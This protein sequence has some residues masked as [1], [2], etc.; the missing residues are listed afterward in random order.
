[1]VGRIGRSAL[2]KEG[3]NDLINTVQGANNTAA[4]ILQCSVTPRIPLFNALGCRHGRT[5]AGGSRHRNQCKTDKCV[6]RKAS[7]TSSESTQVVHSPHTSVSR[8]VCVHAALPMPT[9]WRKRRSL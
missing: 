4:P 6:V 9:F 2:W 3:S 8:S 5:A 1:M 7:L